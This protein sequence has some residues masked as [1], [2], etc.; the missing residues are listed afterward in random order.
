MLLFT[1]FENNGNEV[2]FAMEMPDIDQHKLAKYL[3][4][5]VETIDYWFRHDKC[6]IGY[7]FQTAKFTGMTLKVDIRPI[8]K[9]D[10]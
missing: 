5:D 3:G 4:I 7:I 1:I 2:L 6:K 9:V 10:L 8:A